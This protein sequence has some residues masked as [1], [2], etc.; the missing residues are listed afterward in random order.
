MDYIGI[1]DKWDSI[2]ISVKMNIDLNNEFEFFCFYC[3]WY[4]IYEYIKKKPCLVAL[5][6]QKA[7]RRFCVV[8]DLILI[9]NK[10]Y[11][12]FVCIHWIDY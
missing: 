1:K 3:E 7:L 6:R 9:I 2:F 12:F 5:N 11:L 10:Y 8:F 4:L